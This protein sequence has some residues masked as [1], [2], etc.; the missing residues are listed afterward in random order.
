MHSKRARLTQIAAIAFPTRNDSPWA[1]DASW[2]VG[3]KREEAM[4]VRNIMA[5]ICAVRR[6]DERKEGENENEKEEEYDQRR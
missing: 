1:F 4:I 6:Y 3:Q 2:A 5:V